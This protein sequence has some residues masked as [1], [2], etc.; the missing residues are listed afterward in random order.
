MRAAAVYW[1]M[2]SLTATACAML[3]LWLSFQGQPTLLDWPL[4]AFALS[5]A[6][7]TFS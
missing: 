3:A 5:L 7:W 1:P 2:A 6:F 4:R